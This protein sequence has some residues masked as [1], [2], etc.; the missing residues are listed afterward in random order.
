MKFRARLDALTPKFSD[1][2]DK[3]GPSDASYLI[4]RLLEFA[5]VSLAFLKR[6]KRKVSTVPSHGECYSVNQITISSIPSSKIWTSFSLIF[7][8]PL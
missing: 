4:E 5:E 6:F 8:F 1:A 7:T 3:I 2:I